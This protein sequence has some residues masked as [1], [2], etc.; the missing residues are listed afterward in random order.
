MGTL[1][2]I[3]YFDLDQP[4]G[5]DTGVVHPAVIVTAQLILNARA[6]DRISRNPDDHDS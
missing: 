6:D 3:A 4:A 2:D 1:A 5:R